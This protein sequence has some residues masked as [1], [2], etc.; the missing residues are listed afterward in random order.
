MNPRLAFLSPISR[1]QERAVSRSLADLV[2]VFSDVDAM[3]SLLSR[4]N[5]IVY[6]FQE[7]VVGRERE[8]L[9]ASCCTLFPGKVG[10][11]FYMTQGH[12]HRPADF[13]E[14]YYVQSGDGLLLLQ[15]RDGDFQSAAMRPGTIVYVPRNY[16]HRTVNTGDT[17]L[18]FFGVYSGETDHD[19]GDVP[20]VEWFAKLVIDVDGA[21]QI[22][23]NPRHCTLAKA[24]HR[25][26]HN[27]DE[28]REV[29]A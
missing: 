1:Y 5:P 22:V 25:P 6:E 12:F 13:A 8:D 4:A 2:D 17:P 3:Q 16:F 27:G 23:D 24:T 9:V 19:Y 14:V 29:S 18:Q 7:Y 15:S 20:V 11:E 21:A 10:R 28:R 26:K